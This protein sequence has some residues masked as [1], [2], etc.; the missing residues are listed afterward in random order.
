MILVY[1]TNFLQA[2]FARK[3]DPK[4]VYDTIENAFKDSNFFSTN[5]KETLEKLGDQGESEFKM[6]GYMQ[7]QEDPCT[8]PLENPTTR[9]LTPNIKVFE[10]IFPAQTVPDYNA[11]CDNTVITPWRNIQEHQPQLFI[12]RVRY[13]VY[14]Y[15]W[16]FRLIL[17]NG[18]KPNTNGSFPPE[19]LGDNCCPYGFGGI[20]GK[21]RWKPIPVGERPKYQGPPVQSLT[22][23]L[24]DIDELNEGIIQSPGP[25][26][27]SGVC[28]DNNSCKLPYGPT[29]VCNT[30]GFPTGQ[31][32]PVNDGT[33][34]FV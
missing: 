18:S 10:I 30:P 5:L 17:N 14:A 9:W 21:P 27:S 33:F 25:Q 6:C 12:N 31:C 3:E 32:D 23:L 15:A 2:F 19:D 1:A 7:V 26:S 22:Q 16:Q 8:E 11:F 29:S 4:C 24:G 28:I 20:D 34:G 13:S